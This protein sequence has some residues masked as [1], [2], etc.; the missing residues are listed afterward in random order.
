MQC[1]AVRTPKDATAGSVFD[2]LLDGML[3]GDNGDDEDENNGG[4]DA[5]GSNSVRVEYA[6]PFA[7]RCD[8][9]SLDEARQL[10]AVQVAALSPPEDASR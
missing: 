6:T 1:V 10:A 5:G 8:R 2:L 4:D 3:D 9:P 7:V